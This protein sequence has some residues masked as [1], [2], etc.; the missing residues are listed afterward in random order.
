MVKPVIT[1]P[2]VQALL[3]DSA[4][5][6]CRAE[7]ELTDGWF[8]A[9][10][11][12]RTGDG[13]RAIVKIAPRPGTPVLRYEQGIMSTEAMFCRQAGARPGI[14]VPELIGE[15][16]GFL[17]MSEVEGVSWARAAGHLDAGE[18][19]VLLREL[20]QIVARLHALPCPPG[21]FGCPAPEAGLLANN[22]PAAF[23]AMVEAIL[24]DAARWHSPIGISPAEVRDLL[25]DSAEAL[26]EVRKAS[27]V[28]FD[29]WP[30]NVF[31]TG[32][33]PAG[34]TPRVTGI[35]DHE[36]AFWGDPAAELVS[37]EICGPA[38]P[39][40]DLAAGYAEGG[41]Q[42]SF[43][44]ALRRR[45]GLYRLYFGLILVV[46][47]GPRGYPPE[48]ITWCRARLDSWATAMREL[49]AERVPGPPRGRDAYRHS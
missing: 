40:S 5:I 2:E 16:P 24:E 9:V 30:G 14:P 10:F 33:P 34:G 3:R 26:A 4:G 13:R 31:I 38:G 42:L 8:N 48:H 35:I 22:W 11:Q 36:R 29:L 23:T 18:R 46:E 20:G 15:G 44:P 25:A 41:G 7:G 39:G 28:H 6:R 19:A 12:I 17:V 37:L 21:R 47:C 45:L 43:T 49:R 32:A 27:L 1:G